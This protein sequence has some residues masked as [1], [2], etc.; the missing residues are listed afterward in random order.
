[1]PFEPHLLRPDD[2]DPADWPTDLALLG[3]QLGN[4]ADRLAQRYP[5]KPFS[6][7]LSATLKRRPMYWPRGVA[8]AVLL[9][10]LGGSLAYLTGLYVNRVQLKVRTAPIARVESGSLPNL[11]R[12]MATST[13]VADD[14]TSVLSR[15]L[16]H[17]PY[18][19][20]GF[21]QL[22]GSEQEAVLDL[23]DDRPQEAGDLAI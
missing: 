5:A 21:H 16:Q 14:R 15:D 20:G 23:L 11:T 2:E 4:D 7:D 19:M 18:P 9:C 22:S 3:E 17:P 10:A 8:V 6:P 13:T 12:S 1:M